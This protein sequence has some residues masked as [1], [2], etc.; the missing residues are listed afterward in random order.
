MI[1]DE[2][3]DIQDK[4]RYKLRIMSVLEGNQIN[5]NRNNN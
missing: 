3:K 4:W 1:L 2:M 5:W